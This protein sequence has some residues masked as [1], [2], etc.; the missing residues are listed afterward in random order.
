MLVAQGVDVNVQALSTGAQRGVWALGEVRRRG[1]YKRAATEG[2]RQTNGE[3]TQGPHRSP[4][5]AHRPPPSPPCHHAAA[6]P[7]ASSLPPACVPRA[8]SPPHSVACPWRSLLSHGASGEQGFQGATAAVGGA[9]SVRTAIARV[10][11]RARFPSAQRATGVRA[12]PISG[13]AAGAAG[14]ASGTGECVRD[15]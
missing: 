6:S 15:G 10:G 11:A 8:E 1:G 3:Q 5:R 13:Q 12:N 9:M 2:D 4:C 7:A 14:D